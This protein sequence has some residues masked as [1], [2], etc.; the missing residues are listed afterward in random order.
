MWKRRNHLFSVCDFSKPFILSMHDIFAF[1]LRVGATE[2][3]A[4]KNKEAFE[5]AKRKFYVNLLLVG[6]RG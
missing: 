6:V 2:E 4:A 3:E 5:T 1:K